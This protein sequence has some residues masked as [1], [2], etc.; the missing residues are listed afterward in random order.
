MSSRNGLYE[1]LLDDQRQMRAELRGRQEEGWDNAPFF[2]ALEAR[3][4]AF[5]EAA[6]FRDA[7]QDVT[8]PE[9]DQER[10]AASVFEVES[11]DDSEGDSGPHAQWG[12]AI[13]ASLGRG[14]V[15]FLD[16]AFRAIEGKS[17]ENRPGPTAAEKA[18]AFMVA[19]DETA[20]REQHER[21][22]AD[23]EWRRRNHPELARE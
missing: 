2:A 13:G 9:R 12:N 18:N 1:D 19:S 20:R 4:T 11:S 23:E 16:I 6:A 7:A 21:D 22:V 15:S 14:A 5:D 3:G 8:V 10:S 17:T